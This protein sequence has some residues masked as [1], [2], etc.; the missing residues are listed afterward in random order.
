[1][2]ARMWEAKVVPGRLEEA[3]DHLVTAVVP[4][5]LATAG[6]VGAEA[7]TGVGE[8][9][10]VLITRWADQPPEDWEEG[11]PPVRLWVR[12]HAWHFEPVI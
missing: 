8:E 9:R 3:V 12:E 10:V 5:V 1:V 11:A 7:F 4:A 6:C 2:I